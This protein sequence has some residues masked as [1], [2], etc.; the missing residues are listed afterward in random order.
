MNIFKD[1]ILVDVNVAFWSGAKVLNPE[2]LGL[3]DED[4]ADAYKLGRKM[5][6]P[7]GVIRKFRAIEAKARRVVEIN[8]FPF[9][10]GNARFVPKRKFPEVLETLKACQAE[11]I[12]QVDEL[13]LHYNQYR[14]EMAPVYQQAAEVA[15]L[16]QAPTTEVFSIDTKEQARE[17]FISLFMSRIQAYYPPV[18]ALR[19]K[20]SL[21][22]DV[23]EINI[24]TPADAEEI[25]R[26]AIEQRDA[27]ERR[28]FAMQEYQAKAR[29][30]IDTF[31]Q[32]VVETLRTETADLCNRVIKSITEG[33]VIGSNT[34]QSLSSFVDRFRELNF[35]GDR[36]IED[37]L[38]DLQKTYLN[39]QQEPI[40]DGTPLQVE[41]KRRL[42][43]LVESV[44]DKTDIN[45]VTGEYS[46]K[47]Q[48]DASE[49]GTASA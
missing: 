13:L 37:Q 36:K 42:T 22:W 11:Y 15:F 23:Y 17:E 29:T 47:V 35:V 5:L 33:K 25:S 48:W 34:I 9:P 45:T 30:K 14:D 32:S 4:V 8:S 10:I 39:I 49:V 31:V 28:V 41:L 21:E 1:G 7:D 6:V 26:E 46:R 44:S 19:E 3:K 20:F 24:P 43:E 2:D 18:E 12:S 27:E 40:K 38:D 16:K